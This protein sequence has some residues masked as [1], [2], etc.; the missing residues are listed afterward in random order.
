MADLILEDF[1]K[2]L[3]AAEEKRE[4]NPTNAYMLQSSYRFISMVLDSLHSHM[5]KRYLVIAAR[6]DKYTDDYERAKDDA[7]LYYRLREHFMINMR[8]CIEIREEND[9]LF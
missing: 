1:K 5:E 6:M 2:A 9:Y 3:K 4:H 7:D 8:E